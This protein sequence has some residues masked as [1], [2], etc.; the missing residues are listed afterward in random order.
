MFLCCRLAPSGGVGVY[1]MS[2]TVETLLPFTRPAADAAGGE[3]AAA[4]QRRRVRLPAQALHPAGRALAGVQGGAAAL[5]CAALYCAVLQCSAQHS[6]Y[7]PAR[8][9][10]LHHVGCTC[11][12]PH[13]TAP[14]S[15][16]CPVE[17]LPQ[18]GPRAQPTNP[19]HLINTLINH[20]RWSWRLRARR[21]RGGRCGWPASSSRG[22]TACCAA[23]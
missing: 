17:W 22:R 5:R 16:C 6:L 10:F 3:G 15:A 12:A 8:H 18:S 1:W 7:T 21:G 11:A 23:L 20:C 9:L 14:L 2:A 19:T 13:C 4:A